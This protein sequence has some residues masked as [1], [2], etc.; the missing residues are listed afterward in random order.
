M[1]PMNELESLQ[2]PYDSNDAHA[3]MSGIDSIRK[4][5]DLLRRQ[6]CGELER[7][8]AEKTRKIHDLEGEIVGLTCSLAES[9]EG[10]QVERQAMQ[11]VAD[12]NKN[13]CARLLQEQDKMQLTIDQL[14]DQCTD[15][16]LSHYSVDAMIR[17]LKIIQR[18]KMILP[19][20]EY[21]VELCMQGVLERRDTTHKLKSIISRV[22]DSI[23]RTIES[24]NCVC[25]IDTQEI[26]DIITRTI[27]D[28]SQAIHELKN[29]STSSASSASSASSLPETDASDDNL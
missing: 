18:N 4:D 17:C 13:T 3:L 26:G 16:N 2:S 14:V 12:D 29:N 28:F 21:L 20:K 15:T 11:V 9:Q 8:I 1:N 27:G 10:R 19:P 22:G 5:M 6:T 24:I 25:D 23:P 7:I